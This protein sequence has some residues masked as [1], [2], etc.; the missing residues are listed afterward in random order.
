MSN[1]FI[2]YMRFAVPAV[3]GLVLTATGRLGIPVDSEAAA[4]AVSIGLMVAYY[5]AFRGLEEIAQRMRWGRLQTLA[6]IFLG[7]AR[8]PQYVSKRRTSVTIDLASASPQQ[9]QRLMR[10]V[11]REGLR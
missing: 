5:L 7:W 11:G 4:G 9:L 3:A 1:L 8:P 10:D 2:S 6:G